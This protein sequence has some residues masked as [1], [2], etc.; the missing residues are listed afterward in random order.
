MFSYTHGFFLVQWL[1]FQFI[2]VLKNSIYVSIMLCALL[3]YKLLH[4]PPRSTL[5]LLHLSWVCC[6]NRN[7]F[8]QHCEH[9]SYI[10]FVFPR[11][12][13][14]CN[15]TTDNI[16]VIWMKALIY[17]CYRPTPSWQK[18]KYMAVINI[19][20]LATQEMKLE[21]AVVDLQWFIGE[22]LGTAM[23]VATNFSIYCHTAK[24][25]GLL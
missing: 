13:K 12:M 23:P 19:L 25:E 6:S 20:H 10:F 1:K 21:L 22:Y 24:Q 8:L 7:L 3:S 5:W 9:F 18:Y 11:G 17:L 15:R 2:F 16:H 14:S 4:K